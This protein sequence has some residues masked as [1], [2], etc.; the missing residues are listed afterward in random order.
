MI[1]FLI[2][3][4][5]F[6]VPGIDILLITAVHGSNW[7]FALKESFDILVVVELVVTRWRFRRGLAVVVLVMR[8]DLTE[9][10]AVMFL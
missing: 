2:A 1:W 5:A 9:H 7:W 4:T 10:H 6:V 3:L 8:R